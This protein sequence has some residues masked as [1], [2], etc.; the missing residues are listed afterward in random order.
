MSINKKLIKLAA[1]NNPELALQMCLIN[2]SESPCGMVYL[3][4][5]KASF[6]GLG[7]TAKQFSGYLSAL[8]K[9]GLYTTEDQY[10]GVVCM[11]LK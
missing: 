11:T 8:S 2:E 4:N 1:V 10:F 6:I 7:F 5:A 9:K 3:D